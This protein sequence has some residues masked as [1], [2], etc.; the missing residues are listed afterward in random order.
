MSLV[1]NPP[2]PFPG[3][4]R[5]SNGASCGRTGSQYLPCRV[6]GKERG[7]VQVMVLLD[8]LMQAQT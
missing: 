3:E 4:G 6:F 8:S 1:A 5:I 7:E 2:R